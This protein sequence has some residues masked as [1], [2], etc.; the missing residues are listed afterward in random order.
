M[1]TSQ[2]NAL[3]ASLSIRKKK[4]I[5]AH[6]IYVLVLPYKPPT[7]CI[8][9]YLNQVYVRTQARGFA[10]EALLLCQNT[11]NNIFFSEI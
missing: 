5:N 10:M 8:L 6:T 2:E 7:H 11:R 1:S 3:K 4:Y 9:Y